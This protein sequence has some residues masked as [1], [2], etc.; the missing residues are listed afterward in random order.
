MQPTV[1]NKQMEILKTYIFPD[2]TLIEEKE[3]VS[4]VLGQPVKHTGPVLTADCPADKCGISLSTVIYD[5]ED[6]C[7]K[8]WYVAIAEK[9]REWIGD[10]LL[11]N[12][13]PQ[14]C[15]YAVSQDG[16]NW[17]KP[18]LNI[19][20]FNGSRKNNLCDYVHN[21]G[22]V[23][24][25]HDPDAKKRYKRFMYDSM[26]KSLHMLF[27]PDGIHWDWV[28]KD[29]PLFEGW[30]VVH[31]THCFM[32]WDDKQGKY[33]AFL[34][35]PVEVNKNR[36]RIIGLSMTDDVLEWPAPKVILQ[37]DEFDPWHLNNKGNPVGM[38][39]YCMQGF[40][41]GEYYLG[42]LNNFDA[43][44]SHEFND[45]VYITLASSY[46]L[47]DWQRPLRSRLLSVGN[48]GDYDGGS[49]YVFS[50][51]V[52]HNDEIFIYY[53]AFPHYHI[54]CWPV[55]EAMDP[56]MCGSLGLAKL[57][58]DG[59]C[60]L[61]TNPYPGKIVTV[62]LKIS[63]DV[64][65]VNNL[66]DSK[67]DGWLRIEIQDKN[68]M[69]VPGFTCEECNPIT[70]DGL[71]NEIT[72]TSGKTIKELEEHE[73]KIAIYQTDDVFYALRFAEYAD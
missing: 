64:I 69:P 2:D 47:T 8:T 30:D 51:P 31:D 22:L 57:R 72:W 5:E 25:Y 13:A 65:L 52:I 38:D 67:K 15:G 1:K 7:F 50:T 28:T 10:P 54:G 37:A 29:K 68:G 62:P 44:Y 24:D 63:G 49:V 66:P 46:N 35:P 27:S 14:Y 11:F 17:D 60:G 59:F 45:P 18:E 53:N 34:R 61:F 55:H 16:I 39:M 71:Y 33:V 4:R 20:E 12:H 73:V 36:K 19:V 70:R 21:D 3:H 42:L 41:Y 58:L 40:R 56:E 26:N 43:H 9:Q 23:K 32:G 48:P 6:N